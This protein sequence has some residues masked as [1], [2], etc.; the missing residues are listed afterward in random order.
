MIFCVD[1]RKGSECSPFFLFRVTLSTDWARKEEEGDQVQDVEILVH[2]Q[3]R[4]SLFDFFETRRKLL[5]QMIG[6]GPM[7]LTRATT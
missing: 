3:A 1:V 4:R 6:Q 2:H 5:G 7:M